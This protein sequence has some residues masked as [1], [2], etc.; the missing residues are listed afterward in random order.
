[1]FNGLCRGLSRG[2]S[3]IL[4]LY[5]PKV[6]WLFYTL[7]CQKARLHELHLFISGL[8]LNLVGLGNGDQK[9]IY[10]MADFGGTAVQL[11]GSCGHSDLHRISNCWQRMKDAIQY[12][13]AK[14]QIDLSVIHFFH[15]FVISFLPKNW[16]FLLPFRLIDKFTKKIRW[17]S[18]SFSRCWKSLFSK[19]INSMGE[20]AYIS[21]LVLYYF[22]E[23][24]IKLSPTR[25]VR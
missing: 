18:S 10:F 5:S 6:L 22:L 13:L 14:S 11:F 23:F 20:S 16:R 7:T 3:G 2:S 9:D 12:W 4:E 21:F 15:S 8:A 25:Q 24:S 17:I 19:F 1:M